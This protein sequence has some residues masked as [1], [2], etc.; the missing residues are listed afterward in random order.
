MNHVDSL[1]S[2][3]EAL[4]S[5]V[6]ALEQEN[7]S[8]KSR[9]E[10]LERE[11]TDSPSMDP[12]VSTTVN[13]TEVSSLNNLKCA[14]SDTERVFTKYNE[15]FGHCIRLCQ[16]NSECKYVGVKGNTCIGCAVVPYQVQEG[17]V[18]YS[19]SPMN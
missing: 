2:S 13:P 19:M 6:S 14:W 18:T 4:L 10:E 17:W 15:N 9:V 1:K 16:N 5:R 11:P 12:V 8:L 3:N 7:T